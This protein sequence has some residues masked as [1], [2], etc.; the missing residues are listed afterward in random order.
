M[1]NTAPRFYS[2][3]GR[4]AGV[5]TAWRQLERRSRSG[6]GEN[7]RDA[8][9]GSARGDRARA[10][11]AVFPRFRFPGRSRRVACT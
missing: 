1:K 7:L 4:R 5:P 8:R 11:A 9:F 10:R 2:P 3:R 6:N